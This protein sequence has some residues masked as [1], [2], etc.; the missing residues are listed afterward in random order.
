MPIIIMNNKYKNTVYLYTLVVG[1]I[2]RSISD[3]LKD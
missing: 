1:Q 2:N 3:K